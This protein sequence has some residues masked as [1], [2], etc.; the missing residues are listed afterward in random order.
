MSTSTGRAFFIPKSGH[1]DVQEIDE[2]HADV[3]EA[4][5]VVR[6]HLRDTSYAHIPKTREVCDLLQAHFREEE[7]I[8]AKVDYP[9]LEQHILHHD[10]S[11]GHI[12]RV[13][14]NAQMTQH[15]GMDDL[16]D[17][18]RTLLNDI[19]SADMSFS[20]FLKNREFRGGGRKGA[21]L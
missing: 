14:G 3:I 5:E 19:F 4:L 6:V 1:I 21:T 16:R 2:Q 17:I 7:E 11:L 15:L 18:Y 12:Y 20:A 9:H 13:L 10:Q 8:M